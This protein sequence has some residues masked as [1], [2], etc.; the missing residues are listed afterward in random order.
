MYKLIH[1]TK[2]PNIVKCVMEWSNHQQ[3]SHRSITWCI[4][5]RYL[6]VYQS[7][8]QAAP[9]NHIVLWSKVTINRAVIGVPPATSDFGIYLYIGHRCK[10][11]HPY[12]IRVCLR[13]E[14]DPYLIIVINL[15]L[16]RDTGIVNHSQH[17][18]IVD[19]YTWPRIG[20]TWMSLC[21]G[22]THSHT[23]WHEYWLAGCVVQNYDIYIY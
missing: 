21:L 5:F 23:L 14:L 7:S 22:N 3:S 11:Y 10:R 13:E 6:T 9:P 16:G 18:R 15:M 12:H 1:K 20:Y 4:G 17:P 19:S 2:S 8:L